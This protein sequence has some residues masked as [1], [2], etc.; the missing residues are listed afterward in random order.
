[1]QKVVVAFNE[2]VEDERLKQ[3]T[4]KFLKD[5]SDLGVEAESIGGGVKNPK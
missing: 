5:V 3:L 4:E 2:K 1:M